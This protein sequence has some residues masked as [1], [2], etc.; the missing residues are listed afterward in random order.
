[1]SLPRGDARSA[2]RP[3]T[4][5]EAAEYAARRDFQAVGQGPGCQNVILNVDRTGRPPSMQ[6]TPLGPWGVWGPA[7][8]RP[9][10]A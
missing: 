1:M 3:W 4:P 9:R 10:R 2:V 6:F 8:D 7:R 5:E